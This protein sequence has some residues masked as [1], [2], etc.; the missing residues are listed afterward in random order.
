M[1][2]EKPDD[3]NIILIV[4]D[5]LRARNLGCYNKE[6]QSSPN[7]DRIAEKGILFENCYA[8]WNTTDQSLTSILTGRYPRTHGIIHHGDKITAADLKTFESLNTKLLAEIL[9]KKGYKT[10]AVDW[11]GRWFK[12]GFDFYGYKLKKNLLRRFIYNLFSLPYLHL[13]YILANI[14][15]LKIY[16][17]KRKSSTRS[18]WKGLKDVLRTFRFTFELA[19]IQDAGH[20]TNLAQ[21]LIDEVKNEKFFLFLHYWDTHS[22]YNC[23]KKYSPGRK[24]ARDPVDIYLS[25]YYGAV[26]YVDHNIGK[27]LEFLKE[28]NLMDN[29]LLILTSDHGESLNEHDIFFDHHG[30][31][32]ETTHVPFILNNPRGFMNTGK[33]NEFVQHIDLVPTLCHLLN[34]VGEEFEFDGVSLMGL[35]NGEKDKIRDFA[36]SEESYVQRKLALR[37][38]HYKYIFAP[39]GV[40][41]CNYCQKVHNGPEEL[42]DLDNNPQETVNIVQKDKA[43]AALMRQK[44]NDLICKLDNKKKR[45]LNKKPPKNGLSEIKFDS[46]EEKKIKKKL[47]SLGY[48]D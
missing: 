30:L 28:N 40:G 13:K 33:I 24:K 3:L 15:L 5:A 26:N 48:L 23:P 27:L 36:F 42:Y 46:K 20:L 17:G 39:D 31:Y 41:K 2:K 34:I 43:E 4:I 32:D 9:K 38:S 44:L 8:C 19:I 37:T 10:F 22:P 47:R 7:I 6:A 21:E 29:T 25:K 35:I 12:K 1:K 14:S 18:N 45:E 16:A 11:M